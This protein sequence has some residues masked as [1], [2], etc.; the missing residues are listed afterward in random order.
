MSNI[1]RPE[2]A[3]HAFLACLEQ[4]NIGD[5]EVVSAYLD[6]ARD[7]LNTELDGPGVN[8]FAAYQ[9]R[10]SPSYLI[11]TV[12]FVS[13]LPDEFQDLFKSLWG[14]D[15]GKSM[16]EWVRFN[17]ERTGTPNIRV[18]TING[19]PTPEPPPQIHK[20][21]FEF[22]SNNAINY[23]NK[24]GVVLPSQEILASLELTMEGNRAKYLCQYPKPNPVMEI[25]LSELQKPD[26]GAT[27]ALMLAR[28]VGEEIALIKS[29]Q[30]LPEGRKTA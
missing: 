1:T 6:K 26:R 13:R 27:I 15:Q 2:G 17:I 28:S 16:P 18:I 3:K 19:Q 8:S 11:D 4:Y 9:A 10:R 29:R 7:A 30:G 21:R 12:S 20:V 14:E 22:L 5:E 24:T 25:S 23:L